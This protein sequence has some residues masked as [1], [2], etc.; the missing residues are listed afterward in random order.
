MEL[1]D[2]YGDGGDQKMIFK[3]SNLKRRKRKIKWAQDKCIFKK[4]YF[5]LSLKR[6]N[7]CKWI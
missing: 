6:P 1:V 3:C 5:V 2:D 4:G 7:G